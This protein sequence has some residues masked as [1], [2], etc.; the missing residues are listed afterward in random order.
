VPGYGGDHDYHDIHYEQF[1]RTQG[2]LREEKLEQEVYLDED[3]QAENGVEKEGYGSEYRV[4]EF[5]G[6]GDPVCVDYY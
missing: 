1:L 5:A 4:P 6:D 3:E 2:T